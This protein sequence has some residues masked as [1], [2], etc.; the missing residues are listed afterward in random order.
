MTSVV[1]YVARGEDTYAA[2]YAGWAEGHEGAG[3]TLALGIGRW[4]DGSTPADRRSFG[5]RCWV[6]GGELR[7]HVHDPAA[8]RYGDVRILGSMLARAAALA[9]VELPEVFRVAGFI[10]ETDPLVRAALQAGAA[11]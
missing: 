3:V 10:A 1:G 5:L 7:M 6:E 8:S 4:A 2:Y 11:A 9:D